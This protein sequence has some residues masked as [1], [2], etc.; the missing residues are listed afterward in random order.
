MLTLANC[1]N[2]Y[3]FIGKNHVQNPLVVALLVLVWQLSMHGFYI[4]YVPLSGSPASLRISKDTLMHYDWLVNL[5][6]S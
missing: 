3:C 6:H 4:M 1:C 2:D 5:T